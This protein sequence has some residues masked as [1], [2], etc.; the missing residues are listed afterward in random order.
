MRDWW[1]AARRIVGGGGAPDRVTGV[2]D[3]VQAY[4]RSVVY[5][6]NACGI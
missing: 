4:A 1:V 3:N 5:E 2:E 6:T